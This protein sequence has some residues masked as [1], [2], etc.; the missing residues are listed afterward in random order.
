MAKEMFSNRIDAD[1]TDALRAEAKRESRS[2]ANMLEL[3]LRERYSRALTERVEV[4]VVAENLVDAGD[5][6]RA[7]VTSHSR[8][9]SEQSAR[10][11][12]AESVPPS[13]HNQPMGKRAADLALRD[14]KCGAD[15]AFGTKCKLCG[16]V[17]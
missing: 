7:G 1:L 10:S 6:D 13:V 3:V 8:T 5:V 16:K 17:H 4:G 14:G 11:V 15:V 9:P 2:V 12:S